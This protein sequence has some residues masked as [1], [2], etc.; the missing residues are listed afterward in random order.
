MADRPPRRL[1]AV[2]RNV[3][4]KEGA[5][6][7]TGEARYIDDLSFPGLLHGRTIRSTVA[8]GEI[9]AVRLGFDTA[10]FTVVDHRDIPGR[11]VV[12]L[13]EASP[14][15]ST[16][17]PQ[18]GLRMHWPPTGVELEART[19]RRIWIPLPVRRFAIAACT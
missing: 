2:G 3:L 15:M 8:C 18:T 5:A 14:G 12:A 7:V 9:A 13:I 10:G 4:R 1:A 6:K 19:A 17:V 16:P 11:N